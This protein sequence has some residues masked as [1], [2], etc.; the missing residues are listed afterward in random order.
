MIWPT[1]PRH[2]RQGDRERPVHPGSRLSRGS[3]PGRSADHGQYRL[4]QRPS[5]GSVRSA[6]KLRDDSGTASC[7]RGQGEAWEGC[8]K[9]AP[10]GSSARRRTG[11]AV[12]ER[13][14][15]VAAGVLAGRSGPGATDRRPEGNAETQRTLDSRFEASDSR[16]ICTGPTRPADGPARDHSCGPTDSPRC[17]SVAFS[18]V[19]PGNLGGRNGEPHSGQRG[20]DSPLR[21]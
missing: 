17:S 3:R 11:G 1:R 12:A 18:G 15:L 10:A 5:H 21:L 20:S 7:G 6:A 16:A 14:A 2:Y 13:G 8:R 4:R 9:A 19:P